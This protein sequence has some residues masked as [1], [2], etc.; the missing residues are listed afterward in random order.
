MR[1]RLLLS[2]VACTLALGACG[3]DYPGNDSSREDMTIEQQWAELMQRPDID[4]AVARYE[5]ME[6]EITSALSTEFGL[7]PWE[8]GG[9]NSSN[10]GC[11]QFGKVDAW[12]A[13]SE[14]LAGGLSPGVI[15]TDQWP[16]AVDTIKRVASAY[17]FTTPGLAVDRGDFHIVN[18]H[19]G[20][21]A[22][23]VVTTGTEKANTVI[24]VFTGCHLLPEA[25]RR[26]VPRPS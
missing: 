5:R 18:L 24:G 19:D 23:L 14:I 25:K 9:Q 3:S 6:G 8:A 16:R 2:A 22:N 13:M 17:G 7:P 12:D 20:Y 1:K 21:A 15:P 10:P 11:G 26:G 4:E